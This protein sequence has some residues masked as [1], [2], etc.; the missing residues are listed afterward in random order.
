MNRRNNLVALLLA[1]AVT[2][3]G[4]AGA[5][6]YANQQ[7]QEVSSLATPM[8]PA[9]SQPAVPEDSAASA[10]SLLPQFGL[11][12]V[13][14]DG[15]AVIAGTAMPDSKVELMIAGAV[16][17]TAQSGPNGDFAIV[18]DQPLTK[19]SH[20]LVLRTTDAKG[21]V[22]TSQETGIVDIPEAGGELVAMVA[23]PGEATRVMQK[24]EAPA[25]GT[26]TVAAAQPAVEA[27]A[28]AVETVPAPAV[29]PLTPVIVSAV[30]VENGRMF[31]AGSGAPGRSVNV[32]VD[33]VL[34]GTV[35]VAVDGSYL[36][37]SAT[38]LKAGAHSIRADMLDSDGL[39]VIA[40]SAVPLLHEQPETQIAAADPAPAPQ[41]AEPA[42]TEAVPSQPV[43]TGASVIIRRGDNLWRVSRRML[44]RGIAFTTIYEANRDQ[45]Q[46]PSL[47]FP[48]QVLQVPGASAEQNG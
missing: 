5:S 44:G 8:V 11:L 38:V 36:L 18:L 23:K 12:R 41:V 1:G 16:V 24:G 13:E 19:G 48:G 6:Y 27:S 30:D 21:A 20:E 33:D 17:A 43:K 9:A 4:V 7:I 37:E 2:L 46:D 10:N 31:I 29:E 15:S 40:R 39:A 28:L 14:R 42:A 32:Y 26:E 3:G 22:L 25:T 45:I 34:A 47:I 35:K